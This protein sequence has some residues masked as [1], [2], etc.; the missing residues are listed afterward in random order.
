MNQENENSN[1]EQSRG[2]EGIP[3]P[4]SV[5]V[6]QVRAVASSLLDKAQSGSS[7]TD[8]AAAVEK[9]AGAL[10]Q[11][12]EV[13]KARQ[14]LGKLTEEILKLRHEN[15]FATK[16]EQSARMRDYLALLT[17]LV[18]IITLAATL[19]V[20]NWQF[21][22]SERDKREDAMDAQWQ[23]AIK[24][25]SS[26]GEL[27]PGVIA[28]QPFLRSEKYGDQARDAAV[29]LLANSSDPAFFTSL[30]GIALTP[31]TS[32]N[33]DRVIRLD[34]ALRA[35]LDPVFGKSW[36]SKIQ[37]NDMKRLT[38]TEA[39]TYNYGISVA[40]ALTSEI[41]G[42]LR[43]Q[44]TG[45]Q[46][47]LSGTY[48]YDADWDNINLNEANLTDVEMTGCNL[49]GAH[50]ERVTQFSG[51]SLYSTAWWEVKSINRPFL[52]YLKANAKF[53]PNALYGPS[54]VPVTKEQY[55]AAVQR[56]TKDLE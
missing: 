47:D 33:F 4:I 25:I 42:V 36:D 23:D 14:E 21:I 5:Q 1:D 45:S 22:R 12:S 38:K 28:L 43:T 50:L 46:L 2:S 54:S 56:L 37:N 31:V 55:D 19:V 53:Q 17:P 49:Q 44:T 52:E 29:N 32:S 27:S 51:A 26:S 18:T 34:R 8:L 6:R 40:P 24:A 41:G 9:A 16:N 10:K 13:D 48:L 30:F 20:Q 39:A 11:A 15:E 7:V 35:R 3:D